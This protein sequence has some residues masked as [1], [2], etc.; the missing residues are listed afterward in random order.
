[1]YQFFI[2]SFVD[3][4]LRGRVVRAVALYLFVYPSTIFFDAVALLYWEANRRTLFGVTRA[5][6]ARFLHEVPLVAGARGCEHCGHRDATR[7][8]FEECSRCGGLS[9]GWCTAC[10]CPVPNPIRAFWP[11]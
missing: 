4:L 8:P 2:V 1:M 10:K 11:R 9:H 3:E 6:C 7:H 5:P